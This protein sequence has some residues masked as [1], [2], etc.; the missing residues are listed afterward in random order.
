MTI[1]FDPLEVRGREKFVALSPVE[2][3]IFACVARRGRATFESLDMALEE[4]G[5]QPATR[6]LVLL[7]IRR[8]FESVGAGPPFERLAGAGVRPVIEPNEHA[9]AATV[10]GLRQPVDREIG[11]C[12]TSELEH[13]GHHEGTRSGQSRGSDDLATSDRADAARMQDRRATFL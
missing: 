7:H 8:K 12:A 13:D 2:A 6:S 11:N 10:I 1:T 5:A 3:H 9:S 4:V